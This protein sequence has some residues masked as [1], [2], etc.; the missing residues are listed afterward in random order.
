[1]IDWIR[2]IWVNL[3]PIHEDL[4]GL[5]FTLLAGM[6]FYLFKAR[7]KLIFGRA[8]NSLNV[9]SV[10]DPSDKN[11]QGPTEVYVEK[12]FLQNTGRR[13]ATNVEFVLSDWPNDIRVWQPR[14]VEYIRA[15]KGECIVA[16]PQMAPGELVVIDCVYINKKAAFIASVKCAEA[17]AK[18]VPF[19][20]VRRFPTWVNSVFALLMVFGVAYLVQAAAKLLGV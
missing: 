1:M 15:K 20:T 13:T 10:P 18:E 11:N 16:I 6:I 12:F 8:N 5:G 19:W 3:S 4:I 14:Q 9:L 7:V 17:L 2:T